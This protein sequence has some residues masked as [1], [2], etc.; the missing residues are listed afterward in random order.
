[1]KGMRRIVLTTLLTVAAFVLLPTACAVRRPYG[2][3][4]G[5]AYGSGYGYY[6]RPV[7]PYYRPGYVR[8]YYQPNYRNPGRYYR[9]YPHRNAP[10]RPHHYHR[11]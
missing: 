1:M 4:Q 11:R 2:Y 3:Y 10:V 8:P 5:P 9:V 7:V 6:S